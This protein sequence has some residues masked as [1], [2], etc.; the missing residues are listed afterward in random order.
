M[1]IDTAAKRAA[2]LGAG[3][4]PGVV[5]PVPDG[6]ISAADRASLVGVYMPGSVTITPRFTVGLRARHSSV[7]VPQ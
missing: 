4:T 7:R 6:T 1:A 2:A 3:L 5:L